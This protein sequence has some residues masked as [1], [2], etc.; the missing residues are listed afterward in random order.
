MNKNEHNHTRGVTALYYKPS[1]MTSEI[2]GMQ[3]LQEN[4]TFPHAERLSNVTY[5]PSLQLD[6]PL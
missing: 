3:K 2:P 6:K 4:S 1:G 5:F